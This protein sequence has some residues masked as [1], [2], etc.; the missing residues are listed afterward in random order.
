MN[1]QPYPVIDG[2]SFSTK[3]RCS[4]T[5][6]DIVVP[7]QYDMLRRASAMRQKAWLAPKDSTILIPAYDSF[8][9]QIFLKPASAIWGWCFVAP[10][11]QQSAMEPGTMSFQVRDACDDVPL[12]SEVVT[13]QAATAP[14]KTQYLSRLLIVGPPGALN[15]TICNT[16][17]SNQ[18]A[19]LVLWG[20]EPA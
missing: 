20:G 13:R 7:E 9:Y 11:G 10:T 8:E 14:Y 18:A 16:F 5:F 4:L 6:R 19:Q 12:F 3:Q 15:I 2:F 1:P 17:A